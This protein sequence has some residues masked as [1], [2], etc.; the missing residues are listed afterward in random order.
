LSIRCRRLPF[1]VV[2]VLLQLT[3][4]HANTHDAIP[5]VFLYVCNGIV[6]FCL[7]QIKESGFRKNAIATLGGTDVSV[8]GRVM[9]FQLVST[10]QSCRML[11]AGWR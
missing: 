8:A 3:S 4:K 2:N 10:S 5:S 11:A 1:G 7:V 9:R 6:T